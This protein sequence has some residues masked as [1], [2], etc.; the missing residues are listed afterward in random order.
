MQEEIVNE[1]IDALR[2]SMKGLDF[3]DDRFPAS[4]VAPLLQRDTVLMVKADGE[5]NR[6]TFNRDGESFALNGWGKKRT[7]IPALDELIG[8]LKKTT[9]R[10]AEVLC[11]LYAMENGKPLKLNRFISTIKSHDIQL[12][13]EKVFIG[14]WDVLSVNGVKLND[15]PFS[16]RISKAKSWTREC[17]HVHTLPHVQPQTLDGVLD[18]WQNYVV[19][20]G[21]EGLVFRI[22]NG[23][24]Y[25]LKPLHDLD[26]V[27]IGVNKKAYFEKEKG[28]HFLDKEQVTTVKVAL[29]EED[30][31]FIEVS[32]VASGIDPSLRKAL[33]KLTEFKVGEDKD[34]IWIRPLFVVQLKYNELF[35]TK[36]SRRLRFSVTGY[37]EMER[38]PFV[39]CRS[40]RLIGFRGDKQVSPQ[41]LRISQ[42][43]DKYL[44]DYQ[45]AFS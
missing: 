32:D 35:Q 41:D 40:P 24:V 16:V 15:Q 39:R 38:R 30:D 5:F 14:I 26:A 2:P 44:I 20:Q 9:V 11:E 8:A 45:K 19:E 43:P 23:T 21:Y 17:C 25:K 36:E 37:V 22:P 10:K 1:N 29:M 13:G 28:Q 33:W 7:G 18:F 31:T 6:V 12:I 42:I 3:N 4:E 34:V 27:I